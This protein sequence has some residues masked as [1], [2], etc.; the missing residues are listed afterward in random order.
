MTS[1]ETIKA[2]ARIR[3]LAVSGRA[4]EIRQRH[5]LSLTEMAAAIPAGANTVARWEVGDRRPRGEAALRWLEILDSLE[6]ERPRQ[7]AS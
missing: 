1:I 2:L 7:R 6:A 5:S 4:R 3:E